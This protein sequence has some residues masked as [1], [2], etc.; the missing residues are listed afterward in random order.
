MTI[1]ARTAAATAER[2][3]ALLKHGLHPSN[4]TGPR[5]ESRT[6]RSIMRKAA[7]RTN[8]TYRPPTVDY[9]LMHLIEH[10]SSLP[11][12]SRAKRARAIFPLMV[13]SLNSEG[14]RHIQNLFNA[15][16]T[17]TVRYYLTA[18]IR[19]RAG[20]RTPKTPEQIRTYTNRELAEFYDLVIK[21]PHNDVLAHCI[22][23]LRMRD[24]PEAFWV[25][26]VAMAGKT[27]QLRREEM[28]LEW[29]QRIVDIIHAH[30]LPGCVILAQLPPNPF[31]TPIEED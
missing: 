8:A 3:L 10:I 5:R 9:E 17:M 31:N 15:I 25:L 30:E 29:I 13:L 12:P 2:M 20:D 28:L 14:H 19:A 22:D 27:N 11:F 1:K 18:Y 24:I 21:Q 6:P 23:L 7:G 16:E 26:V 4:A